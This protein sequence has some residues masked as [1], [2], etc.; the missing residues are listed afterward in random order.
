MPV[1]CDFQALV[2]GFNWSLMSFF[3]F[4][5]EDGIRDLTVTGVQTCALPISVLLSAEPAQQIVEQERSAPHPLLDRRPE[6]EERQQVEREVEQVRMDEHVGEEGPRLREGGQRRE[7]E[8]DDEAR[9]HEDR[10][11][12]E[13]DDQ[14]GDHQPPHPRGHAERPLRAHQVSYPPP[15]LPEFRANRQM[16]SHNSGNS[17]PAARAACGRRLVRVMPGS[18]LASRQKMSP[19]G[20]NRKSTREYPPSLSA[21]CAVSASSWR[22][23]AS[24]VSSA[25]G[26]ISSDMPGVYLHS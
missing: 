6:D 8:R 24:V 23:R 22:W 14:V 12:Q 20:L 19:S 26:K 5:A 21:R 10:L 7:P 13:E 11:L 17:I 25:A 3:F 2:F 15:A 18:V 16:R 9:A 1:A 4:Q